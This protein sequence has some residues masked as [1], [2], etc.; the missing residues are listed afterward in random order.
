M[1][2]CVSFTFH[3]I[4]SHKRTP[5]PT[6]QP[7][8]TGAGIK[9]FYAQQHHASPD[10]DGWVEVRVALNEQKAKEC[11][12]WDP[13]AVFLPLASDR[14]GPSKSITLVIRSV[15]AHGLNT[16]GAASRACNKTANCGKPAFIR[17][18]MQ[19]HYPELEV[20]HC[21][22]GKMTRYPDYWANNH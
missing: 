3:V 20:Y 14:V 19:E 22:G 6:T 7:T 16:A 11:G 2:A 1:Y 4:P 8:T 21:E 10:W 9:R 13:T 15:L 17:D 18:I 12:F 5:Q